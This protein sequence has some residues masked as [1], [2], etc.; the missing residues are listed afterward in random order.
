M[1]QQDYQAKRLREKEDEMGESAEPQLEVFSPLEKFVLGL[2]EE[3]VQ[4][5]EIVRKAQL[6]NLGSSG[7]E[8]CRLTGLSVI[9]VGRTKGHVMCKLRKQQIEEEKE[10]HPSSTLLS[11]K[12][13]A[14]ND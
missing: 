10:R 13:R 1:L 9:D 2:R 4:D 14:P 11:G 8:L 7:K 6:E 3:D 5:K 12:P